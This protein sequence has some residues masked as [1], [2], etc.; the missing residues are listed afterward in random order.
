VRELEII[1]RDE[2]QKNQKFDAVIEKQRADRR[3]KELETKKFQDQQVA[4]K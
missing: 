3:L 1:K 2:V 4:E